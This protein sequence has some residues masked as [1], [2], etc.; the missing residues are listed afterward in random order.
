M[1]GITPQPMKTRLRFLSDTPVTLP[2]LCPARIVLKKEIFLMR[3]RKKG[4]ESSKMNCQ[5]PIPQATTTNQLLVLY[6][7][8]SIL[9]QATRIGTEL[10]IDL[11]PQLRA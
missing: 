5:L 11:T 3:D 2:P 10:R 6:N 9:D 4:G 1:C 7:Q 8:T